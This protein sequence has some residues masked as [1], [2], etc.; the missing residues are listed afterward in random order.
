MY[1]SKCGREIAAG[2]S[3]CKF[4]GIPARRDDAVDGPDPGSSRAMPLEGHGSP[5]AGGY[6]LSRQDVVLIVSMLVLSALMI[7]IFALTL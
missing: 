3:F 7:I 2:A 5:A 4:C 6:A 1:C